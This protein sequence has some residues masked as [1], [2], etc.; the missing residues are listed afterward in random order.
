MAINLILLFLGIVI[1]VVAGDY[2]V[3]GAAAFAR[4]WGVSA[5]IVGLTIVAFGTSAPELVVSIQAV[6]DGFDTSALAL[7]NVVGSNITN[8]LMV[9]G[10]PALIMAIP[11]DTPG[12]TRNTVFAT[13]ITVVLIG[14]LFITGTGNGIARWQGGV[15]FAGIIIYLIWMFKLARSG[16]KDPALREMAEVDE[17]DGLPRTAWVSAIFII[18]GSIGLA[19]GGSLIVEN[20][21]DIALELGISQ[22]VIG[23]TLVAIGTSLPEL[24]TVVVAAYRGHTEVAIGN[25]VGSNIFNI[26]AVLGAASL[27]GPVKIAENMLQIDVWVMLAAIL[28]LL[29][30]II[31]GKPIGRKIGAVLSITYVV[32]IAV[33]G[34]RMMTEAAIPL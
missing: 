23:L 8:V 31:I 21:S 2:L 27:T 24:A 10:F 17:M 9:L 19:V 30:L 18:A 32:Y 28:A 6:L 29:V 12:V 25:V 33:L 1:L 15:L 14:L 3:R 20:A 5:L 4:K 22:A 13:F 11:T 34:H 16:S 7:G 26:L